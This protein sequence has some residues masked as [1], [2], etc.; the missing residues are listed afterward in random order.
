MV[1][2]GR[3]PQGQTRNGLQPG[4]IIQK[5]KGYD[6]DNSM[7]M[8]VSIE[9]NDASEITE[10]KLDGTTLTSRDYDICGND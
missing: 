3:N 10:V 9:W 6:L 2:T 4:D 5:D 1:Q 8:E 7:D